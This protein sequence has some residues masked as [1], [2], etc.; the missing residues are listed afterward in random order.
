MRPGSWWPPYQIEDEGDATDLLLVFRIVPRIAD[1]MAATWWGYGCG[2]VRGGCHCGHLDGARNPLNDGQENKEPDNGAGRTGRR[3]GR[4]REGGEET[5]ERVSMRS[6]RPV[7]NSSKVV[8]RG[9]ERRSEESR[10]RVL[11]GA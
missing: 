11:E 9:N 8:D 5:V 7:V 2:G 6:R 10:G 3:R 1:T 4:D